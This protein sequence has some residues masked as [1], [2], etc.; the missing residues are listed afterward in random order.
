MAAAAP[1]AKVIGLSLHGDRRFVA[2]VLRAGAFGY[3]LKERVYEE[4]AT[5]VRAVQARKIFLS[6]G[7][8]DLAI[9]DCLNLVQDSEVR[10]RTIFEKSPLGI[11]LLDENWRIVASNPA[12]QDLLG[13]GQEEL[14]HQ[15]FS[16]FILTGEASSCQELFKGLVEGVRQACQVEAHY[17]RKNG[18]LS[19]GRLWLS[20]SATGEVPLVIAML[21]DISE[22]KQA[23]A[24]DPRL[25]GK[26]PLHG[27]AAI[28]G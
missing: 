3:L 20:F 11:A 18:Q 26:A 9:Q 8:P 12:L 6:Q 25:P 5:A 13:Y 14:H 16:E 28:S 10:F 23:E 17:R 15:V 24:E 1:L 21:E 27:L 7:I 2:E 4:L 22:Q 19:W